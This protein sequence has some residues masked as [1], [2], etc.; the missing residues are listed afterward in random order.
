MTRLDCIESELFMSQG[1]LTI[2]ILTNHSPAERV[3]VGY[4]MEIGSH[5]LTCPKAIKI[6][7]ICQLLKPYPS[8][9]Q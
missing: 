2:E 9:Q 8:C 3:S 7:K 4:G 1:G 6:D 5:V